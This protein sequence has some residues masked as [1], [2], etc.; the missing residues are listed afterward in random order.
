MI[1]LFD[2]SGMTVK[3]VLVIDGIKKEYTWDAGRSL[4]KEY[5]SYLSKITDENG[6]IIESI[7]GIGLFRGPGSYTGLR[8]GLTI[9]NTLADS[10][11]VPIV[12][13]TGK[14][15][16]EVCERR[17]EDGENDKLVLPEYGADARVTTP[18]K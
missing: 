1:V 10:L 15:W 16:E 12:G 4:A 13:A 17:L 18:K 14:D 9:F 3:T 6:R 11:G 8:I 5:L 2:C 7:S